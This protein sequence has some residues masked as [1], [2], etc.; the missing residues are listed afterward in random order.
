MER[1]EPLEKNFRKMKTACG[2]DARGD[3]GMERGLARSAHPP[4]IDCV[5]RPANVSSKKRFLVK[6]LDPR[7]RRIVRLASGRRRQAVLT[8]NLAGRSSVPDA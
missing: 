7:G 5:A 2:Q 4:P 1:T 6:E 8:P 3:E